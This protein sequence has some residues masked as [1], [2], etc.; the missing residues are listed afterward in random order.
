[1][2]AWLE[3]IVMFHEAVEEEDGGAGDG[4]DEEVGG[5]PGEV[6]FGEVKVHAVEAGDGDDGE[7]EGGEDGQDF[8]DAV[9]LHLLEV[10]V[11]LEG[12]GE[13]FAVRFGEVGDTGEVIL[14]VTEVGGEVGVED[15]GEF[16]TDHAAD[17]L[18]LWRH[19]LAEAVDFALEG[20]DF[21]EDVAGIAEEDAAFEGGE[22]AGEFI[23]CGL[24]VIEEDVE[25]IVG[26]EFWGAGGAAVFCFQDAFGDGVDGVEGVVVVGDEEVTADEEVE[27]GCLEDVEGV[28]VV[29]LVDDHKDV[30]IIVIDFRSFGGGE[31]VFD[32]EGVETEDAFEEGFIFLW[33]SFFDVGPDLDVIVIEDEAE[34]FRGEVLP[35]EFSLIEDE[36]TDHSLPPSLGGGDRGDDA[37]FGVGLASKSVRG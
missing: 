14:E 21:V 32:G 3:P 26:E 7:A 37:L 33:G 2:G 34:D 1:M 4:E 16:A 31:A 8:D 20:D 5:P 35:D 27:L 9:H 24:I 10:E 23:E 28:D 19:D 18:A 36:G 30:V 11:D 6:I 12:R 13:G 22:L 25:D 15:L 29:D 17:D